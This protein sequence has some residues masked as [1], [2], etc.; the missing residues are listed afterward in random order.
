MAMAASAGL[1]AFFHRQD[2]SAEDG[3]RLPQGCEASGPAE[4][5]EAWL[6]C[7]LA[8]GIPAVAEVKLDV[9]SR[10]NPE[11]AAVTDLAALLAGP[12]NLP[13]GGYVFC[14]FYSNFWLIFGKL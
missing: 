1:G 8:S 4:D 5:R 10:K 12:V 13:A 3:F 7:A 11:A 2:D 14:N 9:S 6:V